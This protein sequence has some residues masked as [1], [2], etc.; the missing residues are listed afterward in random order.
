M[1]SDHSVRCLSVYTQLLGRGSAL[2]TH[3]SCPH[4][5]FASSAELEINC[6]IPRKFDNKVEVSKMM[7]FLSTDY[8]VY[9]SRGIM[10]G[11]FFPSLFHLP[12]REDN[13][14]CCMLAAGVGARLLLSDLPGEYLCP[15]K[16]QSTP[17]GPKGGEPSTKSRPIFCC[18][19]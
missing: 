10:F 18:E 6:L 3:S 9:L 16:P 7:M 4:P 12:Q 14:I 8:F 1:G 15:G 5:L 13:S 17:A 2:Q 11:A 19:Y